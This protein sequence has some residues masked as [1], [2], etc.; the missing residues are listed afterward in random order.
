MNPD[1]MIAKMLRSPHDVRFKDMISFLKCKGVVFKVRGSHWSGR[2][3]SSFICIQDNDGRCKEY[4]VRQ[5]VKI[6]G[7]EVK[8]E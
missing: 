4:Q 8:D 3:E 7:L 5:V 2:L 1:K 6:L